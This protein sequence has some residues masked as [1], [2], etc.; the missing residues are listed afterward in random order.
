MRDPAKGMI[1]FLFIPLLLAAFQIEAAGFSSEKQTS[2]SLKQDSIV[3]VQDSVER[4]APEA[5]A[6]GEG[7]S[8]L[9]ATEVNPLPHPLR[10]PPQ[11]PSEGLL[12]QHL[13]RL[14]NKTW[15]HWTRSL[16]LRSSAGW[17]RKLGGFRLGEIGFVHR[18]S[19]TR[20]AGL[21]VVAFEVESRFGDL[22]DGARHSVTALELTG[23]RLLFSQPGLRLELVAGAGFA[24]VGAELRR[25][26]STG[27]LRSSHLDGR[28]AFPLSLGVRAN[29]PAFFSL[30]EDRNAVLF[31]EL[32]YRHLDKSWTTS[33]ISRGFRLGGLFANG[34]LMVR[35]PVSP[36]PR[37][38]YPLGRD[39][40]TEEEASRNPEAR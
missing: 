15:F 11:S 12:L 27:A 17:A 33:G 31:G 3:A 29:F 4:Q 30:R 39:A 40:Q 36:S 25:R 9:P 19:D 1:R 26:N 35:F 32:R 7:P 28:S 2:R 20:R 8:T 22:A 23:H 14:Q 21:S 5:P 13:R 37:K 34:G 24:R 6:P 38:P 10:Y 16:H 18:L